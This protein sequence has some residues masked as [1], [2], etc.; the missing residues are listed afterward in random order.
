M[1][2][3]CPIAKYSGKTLGDIIQLDPKALVWVATKYTGDQNII[4]AA[5]LICDQALQESA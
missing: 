2:Q 1:K 5:K 4:A 3:P